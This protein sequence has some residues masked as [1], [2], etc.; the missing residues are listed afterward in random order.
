MDIVR[1]F[2][3]AG[4]AKGFKLNI[5]GTPEDPLF[6]ANQ[7]G[8]LLGI[9]NI[10]D[11]IKDFDDDEKHGV[12]TTDAIGRVQQTMFLTEVGLYRLLGMSRKP[13]ARPFQ[14]WVA[15]VVKEIRLTGKFEMEQR[16]LEHQ[17]ALEDKDRIIVDTNKALEDK[18]RIIEDKDRALEQ[19]AAELER[20]R[21]K[22][23]DEIPLLDH[24]YLRK[25]RSELCC[26]NHKIGKAIDKKK[27]ES[28]LN[29]A[30]A[31]GG[32][33]IYARPVHNAKIVE[34]I[35]KVAQRRY[36]I[37][38]SGGEEHYN[39]SVEHSV[40]VI[41]IGSVVVDTLTSSFEHITRTDLF[42]K[43]IG[44]LMKIQH[45]TY[46]KIYAEL[47]KQKDEEAASTGGAS[48]DVAEGEAPMEADVEPEPE[49]RGT[50]GAPQHDSTAA[51]DHRLDEIISTLCETGGDFFVYSAD[52]LTLIND[53][54]DGRDRMTPQALASKMD[55]KGYVKKVKAVGGK[56]RGNGYEGL[57]LNA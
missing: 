25:D 20:F 43:V 11:T 5:Q 31:Q 33:F 37:G 22:V 3:C 16:L 35:V 46:E 28:T 19:T 51:H 23:Y 29:C 14:K 26:D 53:G 6:Q 45:D 38:S 18:A 55:V 56:A 42:D 27:R 57:R 49:L 41:D 50:S 9:V 4:V 52:L 7:V 21:A 34:D 12:G 24:V 36:H 48:T 40:D 13:F 47:Q 30:S 44:N 8:A 54:L 32:K 10:R 15:K 1:A 39:N 17:K 2:E